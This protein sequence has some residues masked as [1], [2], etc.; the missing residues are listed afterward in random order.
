MYTFNATKSFPDAIR[1]NH[2]I[3]EGQV[4]LAQRNANMAELFEKQADMII[5]LKDHNL[6]LNQKLMQLNQARAITS[7]PPQI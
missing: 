5:Y 2:S 4:G 1:G 3:G 7:I 6:K